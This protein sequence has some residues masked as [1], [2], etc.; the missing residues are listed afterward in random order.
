MGLAGLVGSGRSE[1]GAALFG[2]DRIR[3]GTLSLKG[4]P[5][6]PANPADAQRRGL[7]LVPEDR[8]IQGLMPQMSVR[9]NATLSVLPRLG[10]G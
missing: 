3:Q 4:K 8:K 5:Y 7:G 2:L 6:T 10:R 9:E 1:L